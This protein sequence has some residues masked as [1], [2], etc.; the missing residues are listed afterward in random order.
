MARSSKGTKYQGGDSVGE[1][2]QPKKIDLL[3]S[4]SRYK[5][6]YDSMKACPMTLT[7]PSEAKALAGI[8]EKLSDRLTEKLQTHCAENGLP[9]PKRR[10]NG[11]FRV[12]W[13]E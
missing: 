10:R 7:H 5:K 2:P 11:E 6:A 4:M 12:I 3:T 8:G 13:N 1:Y 9:M